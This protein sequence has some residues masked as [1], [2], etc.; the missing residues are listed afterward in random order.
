MNCF[1]TLNRIKVFDPCKDGWKKLLASLGKTKADDESLPLL[2]ILDSNGIDD[3]LW[4]FRAIDRAPW[5]LLY[6]ADCAEHVLHI[7]EKTYPS[8]T[9]VR[10]C[11]EVTRRFAHGDATREDL[12]AAARAAYD[13]AR[14]AAS[15]A[16]AAAHTAERTWQTERLRWYLT[17][18]TEEASK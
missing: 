12:D 14:A 4:A 10:D 15:A 18:Y 2:Y 13:A 17:E 7:Y 9:R 3:A 1:T 11:I 6:V 16:R 5:K 8:D